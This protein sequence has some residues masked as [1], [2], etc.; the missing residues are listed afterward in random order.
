MKKLLPIIAIALLTGC[1]SLDY[2]GPTE[3][4]CDRMT[5]YTQCIKANPTRS[6]MDSIDTC[7]EI[8]YRITKQ[9]QTLKGEQ[10]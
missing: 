4:D 8:V 5:I 7:D 6:V 3:T 10:P 9:Q 1:T 2:T